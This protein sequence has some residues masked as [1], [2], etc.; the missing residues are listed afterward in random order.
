MIIDFYFG[1]GCGGYHFT[2]LDLF[3][4]ELYTMQHII[5]LIFI[6]NVTLGKWEVLLYF[7]Y[8]ISAQNEKVFKILCHCIH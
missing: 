4:Y 2:I 6:I 1:V 3:S 7:I 5:C 8:S